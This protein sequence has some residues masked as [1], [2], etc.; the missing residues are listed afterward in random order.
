MKSL[1]RPARAGGVRTAFAFVLGCVP[2][3]LVLATAGAIGWWGH[4]HEWTVP[5]FSQLNGKLEEKDDWCAEHSVPESACVECDERRLPR[6]KAMGWC[7]LHGIPECTLCN[8]ALAQ[9]AATPEVSAADRGRAKRALDF[10]PRPENN[11][12]CK[13]Q[14]RRVQLA[15]EAAVEKA[16]V[17]VEP[18]GFAPAVEFVAAPGEIGYDPTRVVHLSSRAPGTVW[19][20]F[21]QL[22]ARVKQ[23][24]VLAL[25]DAAE[26]GKAKSELL[27]SF[28]A[29]Q[30]KAQT[31]ASVKSSGGAVPEARL[32]EADAA[33]REAEIR[34]NAARQAL[35]NFG[36][37]LDR[38]AL[39]GAT[40]EQLEARI[41][42]L[43][44]PAEV[45]GALDAAATTSNLLP[46]VAA[47][48]GTIV[49]RDIV[50]GEVVDSARILFEV[51]DT[52]FLWITFDLKGEDAK[53]L[54]LG[55]PVR[56]KPDAD[57]D[58]LAGKLAW[59]S[60]QADPKT[61]TV[62]ARAD[63]PDPDGKQRANSF[64]AGR[65]ILRDEPTAVTV[66]NEALQSDGC[67]QLVFVRDKD[68]LKPDA[69]KVF[70]VRKVR[71]GAKTDTHTE[72]PAGV[73]PGELVATK[74]SGLLLSELLRG[75]LG[76]G[77]ACHAKK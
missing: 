56:F 28:A 25:V 54:K 4:R 61:R 32:R 70:H 51:V 53:R 14:L 60:T 50:A 64:G 42:F 3:L 19:R 74:G 39:Q 73:L 18:V 43:G 13:T 20:V 68:Y 47:M 62:K 16:G 48:D 9:L 71:T 49:S 65:V 46:L 57:A 63:L 40:A 6:P 15:D 17:A 75:N 45:R 41:H 29:V 77:C 55:L 67:C 24:D 30:S 1:T 5:K 33:S 52:R 31:L 2:T 8:P 34:L 35:V 72:I 11:P 12:I 59:I 27:L 22:G 10:A 69:P 23:G 66:P 44:I 36:L 7:K 21:K 76:E 26:V 37:P 38:A 58:E